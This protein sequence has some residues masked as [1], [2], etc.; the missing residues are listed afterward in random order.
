LSARRICVVIPVFHPRLEILA[1]IIDAVRPHVSQVVIVEDGSRTLDNAFC[2]SVPDTDVTRLDANC[3][4]AAAINA[5]IARARLT[6]ASHVL[7]L[8]QDSI[9][10]DQMLPALQTAITN[11]ESREDKLAAVGARFLDPYAGLLSSFTRLT[12]C[13]VRRVPCGDAAH[14]VPT[15]FLLSSGTMMSLKALD[16][17]GPMDESL[18]IDNVDTE[19]C[20]RA[21]AQ[22]YRLYGVCNAI[23]QHSLGESAIRMWFGRWRYVHSHRPFRYYYIFRNTLSL[24]RRTYVPLG[25]CLHGLWHLAG[26]FALFG[27]AAKDRSSVLPYMLRGIIDGI[28]GARGPIG[29]S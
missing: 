12:S 1:R 14:E 27:I 16:E 15:D 9:P 26:L 13:G 17:V 28:K 8:D 4:I 24:M 18:F 6:Q 21:R 10:E 5:G 20:L 22:G 11:L 2:A 19:W 3:G 23:L 25:W 29:E 7:L